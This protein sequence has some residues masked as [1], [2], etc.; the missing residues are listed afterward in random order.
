MQVD[1][2]MLGPFIRDARSAVTLLEE[3]L[4][5]K[6]FESH[7]CLHKFIVIIHGIKSS[8]WNIGEEELSEAAKGLEIEGL[9]MERLEIEGL[10]DKINLMKGAV[11]GFLSK[12]NELIDRLEA[13]NNDNEDK[14]TEYRYRKNPAQKKI[15]FAVDDNDFNLI[16]ASSILRDDYRVFTMGSAVKMFSLMEK[17]RPD[18]ILLDIEMPVMSGF[19]AIAKLKESPDYKNIPVIF[20]TG[21]SGDDIKAEVQKLGA[22]DIIHKPAQSAELLNS[23]KNHI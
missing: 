4:Q 11:P 23:V 13:D 19:E 21:M 10:G 17:I 14:D 16:S 7:K 18:L 20:L 1:P 5:N 8:L 2:G 15:I 6:D 22:V 12:L 3:L 9:E